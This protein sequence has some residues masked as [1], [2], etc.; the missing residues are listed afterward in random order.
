MPPARVQAK[1]QAAW[2]MLCASRCAEGMGD[3]EGAER[4]VNLTS[5]RYPSSSVYEWFLFCKRTGHGDAGAAQALV[6]Q[7]FG[8]IGEPAPA[9]AEPPAPGS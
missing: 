2:A 8:A 6:E 7:Y 5:R 9:K 1:V 3:W 4:W